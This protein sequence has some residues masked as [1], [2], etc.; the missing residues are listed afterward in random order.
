MENILDALLA[1]HL[2]PSNFI[3]IASF[4][5]SYTEEI[6]MGV[7]LL[8]A[9]ELPTYIQGTQSKMTAASS[10]RQVNKIFFLRSA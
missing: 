5:G 6:K 8:Y 4:A 2:C 10:H 1:G 9:A 3:V 7:R